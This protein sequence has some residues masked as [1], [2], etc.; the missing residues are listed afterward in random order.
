MTSVTLLKNV[1][2]LTIVV[3][4]FLIG[5]TRSVGGEENRQPGTGTS[6]SSKYNNYINIKN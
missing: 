5:T 3:F 2:I 6:K 1:L 4:S